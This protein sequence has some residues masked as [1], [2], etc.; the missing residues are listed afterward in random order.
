MTFQRPLDRL[1]HAHSSWQ[2]TIRSVSAEW[3][4]GEFRTFESRWIDELERDY[5]VLLQQSMQAADEI[6]SAIRSL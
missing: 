6:E 5:R 2:A 4:D 3:N 1:G